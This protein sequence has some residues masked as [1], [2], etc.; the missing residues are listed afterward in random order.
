MAAQ[1]KLQHDTGEEALLWRDLHREES[2][3]AH[4]VTEYSAL[5]EELD[6]AG[7]GGV[8]TAIPPA[9]QFTMGAGAGNGLSKG[10]HHPQFHYSVK[11]YAAGR[12]WMPLVDLPAPPWAARRRFDSSCV[13]K[14][15]PTE[16]IHRQITRGTDH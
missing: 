11:I 16:M 6:I 13:G 5:M 15:V 2:C 9:Q 1:S 3:A 12:G 4:E 7:A 10:L 8:V 14:G